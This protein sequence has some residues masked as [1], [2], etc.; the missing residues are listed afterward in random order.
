[1]GNKVVYRQQMHRES[2]L[3]FT[4]L[5]MTKPTYELTVLTFVLNDQD[6]IVPTAAERHLQGETK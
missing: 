5:I 6:F 3:V 2:S 4:D 1:M